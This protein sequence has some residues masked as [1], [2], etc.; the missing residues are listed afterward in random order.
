MIILFFFNQRED[1]FN[2]FEKKNI[3][4]SKFDY[5]KCSETKYKYIKTLW[6]RALRT[7][8]QGVA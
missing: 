3:I 4:Q 5:F 6:K 8:L 7:F 1:I 2:N